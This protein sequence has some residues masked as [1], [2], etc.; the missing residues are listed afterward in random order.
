MP[1]LTVRQYSIRWSGTLRPERSGTHVFYSRC[2]N[3]HYRIRVGGQIII[4]TWARERNGLHSAELQLEA[5]RSYEVAIEWRKTRMSGNMKF[6][7]QFVDGTV[8]GLAECVAAAR[9]AD[10]AVLAVG[11]DPIT[12]S[13]GYDR[14]FRLHAGLEKLLAAVTAAQPNTVVV[15]TAG[16]NLDMS[17][18]IDNARGVLHA[19]YPGQAGGQ[20]LAEILLGK[21]N[22]SGRLPAT[23]EKR[24][25]DRSSFDS[26][27]DSGD[28]RVQLTDGIFTGYRH[29]DRTG[30]KPRFPFGFGLS[31]TTFALSGLQLSSEQLLP[32]AELEVSVDVKNTG[33]RAGA[34]VVQLYLSALE[35]RVPR[36]VKELAAFRKVWLEPGQS[37]RVTLRVERKAFEYYDQERG[38]FRFD[39][40]RYAVSVGQNAGDARLRAE[41]S[42]S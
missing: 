8:P 33:S 41:L 9:R 6:G 28:L 16:G 27:H 11:F 12:E 29:F 21:V 30:V 38:G 20:A 4:D 26:Y 40:G 31:Y 32:G 10:A 15:L 24:L 18:W 35:P 17:G 36:P 39:P 14:D 25:E 23:F 37:T 3:G 2:R 19:W 34:E 5:G 7:Y 13:E 42:A 1:E 22:P